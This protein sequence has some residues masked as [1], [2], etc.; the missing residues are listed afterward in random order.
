MTREQ[1]IKTY[2][3]TAKAL[4]T[5]TGIFPEVM[6]AQA[7]LESSGKVNGTWLV[8]QS[9]LS[10][11]ANNYFG[12]KSTPSWRGETISLKTGEV[13][14]GQRV[15]VTGVFRKYPTIA[16]SFK[17]YI[18]F[19]KVNPR[20]TAAGVFSATTPSAQTAA[21]QRAGYATD[22]NYSSLLNSIIT[23]FKKWIPAATIAFS[24]LIPAALIF[25]L[26]YRKK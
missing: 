2:Y 10:R 21:L 25:F 16:D 18:T 26:I 14:N 13:V 3:N 15:T 4:T 9:L 6:L 24:F 8:G 12:I 19:L 23:G 7:I 5:G 20:Y 17:D 11:A 22:P 1:F